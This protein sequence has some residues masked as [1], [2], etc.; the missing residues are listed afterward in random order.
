M[1]TN[2]VQRSIPKLKTYCSANNIQ[3]A[4]AIIRN[5][6]GGKLGTFTTVKNL[7]FHLRMLK[8]C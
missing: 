7:L 8:R 2:M 3:N 6:H 1:N 5:G 4:S